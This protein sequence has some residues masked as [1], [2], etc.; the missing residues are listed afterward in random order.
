M[1]KDNSGLRVSVGTISPV[2]WIYGFCYQ[3]GSAWGLGLDMRLHG[4]RT[5]AR[6]V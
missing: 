2:R 4:S 6:S 3:N 1:V 5:K